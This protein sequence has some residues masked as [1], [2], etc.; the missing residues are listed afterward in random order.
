MNWL[1]TIRGWW[2]NPEV[3]GNSPGSGTSPAA[4]SVARAA[5]S[6]PRAHQPVPPEEMSHSSQQAISGYG[7]NPYDTYTWELH[8]EGD[9]ERRL[10]RTTDVNRRR[11]SG[12]PNNPYDTGRFT[13]GW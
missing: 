5:R 2:R 9:D 1:D 13:G 11:S 6:R 4:K 12:D 8:T 3:L 7:S 10:K